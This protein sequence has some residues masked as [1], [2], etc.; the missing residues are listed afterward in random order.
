MG[1]RLS[2]F[3]KVKILEKNIIE[4]HLID[5]LYTSIIL[6]DQRGNP[7][8]AGRQGGI[9][10]AVSWTGIY[11]MAL[12]LKYA[13]LRDEDVRVHAWDVLRAYRRL[14]ELTSVPGLLARGYVKG[15]G[16]SMEEKLGIGVE[17]VWRQG[18][19]EL[20]E[21]RWFDHPSHHNYDH[22][23]R[24][25]GYYY[26]FAADEEQKKFIREDVEKIGRH[27]YSDLSLEARDKDGKVIL[28]LWGASPRDRPS[29]RMLMATSSLKIISYITG[30][31]LF[32]DNYRRLC[33]QLKYFEYADKDDI[34]LD[35]YPRAGH[36]D[37]EHVLGDLFLMLR[38]EED[39]VLRKFYKRAIEKIFNNFRRDKYTPF[40][41]IYAY[42]TEDVSVVEDGIDTLHRYPMN[43]VFEPVMNSIREDY[44][45][46]VP[47]PIDERPLDN[48]Y[49]WKGNPYKPD[50]W[51]ARNVT[52]L[53]VSSEDPYVMFAV[54]ETGKLYRSYSMGVDWDYLSDRLGLEVNDVLVSPH[55]LR[56][57]LAATNDGVY[58]SD[59]GGDSWRPFSLKGYR[60]YRFI[61]DEKNIY[62][63]TSEGIY[64]NKNF[65]SLRWVGLRWVKVIDNLPGLD[66][67]A[68][69]FDKNSGI[70]YT[71]I[72]GDVYSLFEGDWI[73]MGRITELTEVVVSR[74]KIYKGSLYGVMAIEPGDLNWSVLG[75]SS[76][77]G[78]S[79]KIIG[80]SKI[81]P[82]QF[83]F[84]SGLEGVK[85]YD[86]DIC[87]KGIYVASDKGVIY[88]DDF[89]ESWRII[90]QG[91]HIPLSKSVF[92]TVSGVFVSGPSGLYKLSQDS[93][94]RL[95]VLNGPGV[96]RFET[97]SVDFVYAY[98]LGRYLGYIDESD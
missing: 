42:V 80:L 11:L 38:L 49:T 24:G 18:S 91:L 69:C 22:A 27:V 28:N 98:W 54:D 87:D 51:L 52:R 77:Y 23:V 57:V 36:D 53:Y 17:K 86:F 16:P 10:H 95:L 72:G 70:F 78:R 41:F 94:E 64:L 79:W 7:L 68:T 58:R 76:D 29:M 55:T 9:L 6:V 61:P 43:K 25:Y 35:L 60:V 32:E 92:A 1:N 67:W 75:V 33:E 83:T 39:D 2:L 20:S 45:P 26:F 5:G 3:E 19:G 59:D 81:L 13:V 50:G 89:G 66:P 84:G 4:R 65:G 74:L 37:A 14:Q 90:N 46:G 48:E 31:K 34:G 8:E 93:W 82:G 56:I 47:L 88:S 73:Y 44:D 30:D 71:V 40:N 62:A 63:I 15:H 12:A 85:V 21:Y 96:Y 97:G